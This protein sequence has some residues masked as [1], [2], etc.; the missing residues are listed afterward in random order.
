MK[1][2]E[3]P[4]N[5]LELISM[6]DLHVSTAEELL[7]IDAIIPDNFNW[8]HLLQRGKFLRKAFARLYE[9]K[10]KDLIQA[11]YPEENKQ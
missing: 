4:K 3:L 8:Y 10:W 2:L 7:S 5:V 9:M 1:L 6:F 11:N